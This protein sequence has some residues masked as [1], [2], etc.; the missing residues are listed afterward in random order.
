MGETHEE[1]HLALLTKINS[2]KYQEYAPVGWLKAGILRKLTVRGNEGQA[3]FA[4]YTD[5][6]ADGIDLRLWLVRLFLDEELY[7]LIP[8]SSCALRIANTPLRRVDRKGAEQV[9]DAI[10][11]A[12]ESE[13]SGV[14][15]AQLRGWFFG[16]MFRP[17]SVEY[18]VN[19]SPDR[20][21][22]ELSAV[23]ALDRAVVAVFWLE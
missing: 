13:Q 6:Q 9:V 15:Y 1:Q 10:I 8:E 17:E 11:G 18:F 22:G 23:V 19:T 2:L 4:A 5:G 7:K 20:V 21:R 14:D 3:L 16:E 12:G